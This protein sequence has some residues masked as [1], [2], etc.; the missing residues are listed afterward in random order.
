MVQMQGC[1]SVRVGSVNVGALLD[2][3]CC[4]F[5]RSFHR[6]EMEGSCA[7]RVDPVDHETGFREISRCAKLRGR[8]IA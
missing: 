5:G 3:E 4:C 8:Q 2:E 6:S 7:K 1:V